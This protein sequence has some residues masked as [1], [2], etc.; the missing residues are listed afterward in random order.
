MRQLEPLLPEDGR[1][2]RPTVSLPADA[3]PW[4]LTAPAVFILAWGGNHFTPL[5]HVYERLGSYTPW[6]SNLLL[7]MYVA[8]LVPGLLVAS[9]LSDRHGRKPLLVSGLLA[10]I[11]GSILLAGG[12]G[13]FLVL[14]VGRVLAGV[15]V[16]V[17]MSVGSTWIKELSSQPFDAVA[18]TTSGARRSSMTLTLGF[19]IG[20]GVTGLLAQWA[21]L[22]TTTPFLL[23]ALLSVVALAILRGT[24]ET[25]VAS[26]AAGGPLWRELV[27]PSTSREGFG[28]LIA[29]AAPWVF[30]AAGIAYAVMP[31]VSQE[32]LGSMSTLYATVLTVVT[33]GA[34]AVAQT[35]VPRI[36]RATGGRG[37][38]VG[39]ALMLVG[40][41]LAAVVA[42]I[43]APALALVVA[44]TLGVAYGVLVVSGLIHVQA[45]AAPRDLAPM[46]GLYYSLCYCGFLLPAVLAALLP[47]APY[48][49]S[50]VVVALLCLLSLVAVVSALR[51]RRG[52][53]A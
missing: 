23:H 34:G 36:N 17:A 37:I 18:Q 51:G 8:G 30:A 26:T 45:M 32:A 52:T 46:T 12:L 3:R 5:L 19:A 16:G 27:V 22:P 10:G 29:P 38:V 33:L 20:A 43:G 9:A 2:S 1:R 44:V 53:A 49:R 4:R 14:C 39:L 42:P 50:L 6:Q 7:G 24:P 28:R 40:M 48:S 35:T 47:L 41:S 21:P 31:A 13:S 11:V 25:T 15:G